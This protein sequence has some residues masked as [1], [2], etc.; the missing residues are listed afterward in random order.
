M[1]RRS[2]KYV[3]LIAGIAV[4]VV[5]SAVALAANAPDKL[6]GNHGWFL[7]ALFGLMAIIQTIRDAAHGIV[8]ALA[9]QPDEIA[10]ALRRAV[11]P[12]ATLVDAKPAGGGNREAAQAFET[13]YPRPAKGGG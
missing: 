10:A 1:F 4:L 2:N 12:A 6:G 11:K 8:A 9:A 7:L 5:L 3:G 13:V